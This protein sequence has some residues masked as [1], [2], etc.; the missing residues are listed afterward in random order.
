M[1]DKRELRKKPSIR[2]ATIWM[3]SWPPTMMKPATLLQM[4]TR[5][6]IGIGRVQFERALEGARSKYG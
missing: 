3:L 6:A 5:L 2:P 1:S 4:S